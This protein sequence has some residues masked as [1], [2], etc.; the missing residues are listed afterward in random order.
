MRHAL[1]LIAALCL[2]L[3]GCLP[4]TR[5]DQPIPTLHLPAVSQAASK[6][7][8]VV[9]PGRADDL[10]SL[11]RSGVADAIRRAWPDTDVTFAELRLGDYRRGDAPERLHRDVM[12]PA[13]A[14]GYREIWLAGASLGGMGT[15]MYDR[16]HPGSTTGLILLAPYLGEGAVPDS[17]AAAGGL[18]RW[19]SP[20]T[21]G[22][23]ER[24]AW[25]YDLWRHLHA[26]SADP[27]AAGRV[28]L[29]YGRE[30][31]LRPSI[32]LFAPA[33]PAGHVLLR[34]GGHRWQVWTPAIEAL[35]RRIDAG[36]GDAGRNDAAGDATQ[37]S[38]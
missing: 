1:L 11:R 35:L 3:T 7:L 33:L 34:D 14:A 20:D 32:E 23:P 22:L 25:Q 37:A 5:A 6:R 4:G 13:Q 2:P 36:H 19:T 38:P 27:A 26:I 12:L 24:D 28:W 9:L 10:A 30:D 29:A 8:V 15:L 17:V 21:A 31:R 16:L 18:S